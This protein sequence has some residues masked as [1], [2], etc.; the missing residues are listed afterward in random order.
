MCQAEV[1]VARSA[2]DAIYELWREA[3]RTISGLVSVV[4]VFAKRIGAP[5]ASTWRER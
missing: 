2:G 3:N 4:E 1:A 5:I